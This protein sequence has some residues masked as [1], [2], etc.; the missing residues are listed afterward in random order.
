MA[1]AIVLIASCKQD[2]AGERLPSA[3][4][5]KYRRLCIMGTI[6]CTL[7]KY[8]KSLTSFFIPYVS[9]G[10]PTKLRLELTYNSALRRSDIPKPSSLSPGTKLVVT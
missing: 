6:G 10:H 4:H 7:S 1:A 9:L 5:V 3:A 8:N 2:L